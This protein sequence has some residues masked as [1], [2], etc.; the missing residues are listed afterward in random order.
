M[1]FIKYYNLIIASINFDLKCGD[2]FLL[3]EIFNKWFKQKPN[4][5]IPRNIVTKNLI[6]TKNRAIVT[7]RMNNILKVTSKSIREGDDSYF[8]N[9]SNEFNVDQQGEIVEL[10]QQGLDFNTK[11]QV[12]SGANATQTSSN[13]IQATQQEVV[14]KVSEL[15]NSFKTGFKQGVDSWLSKIIDFFNKPI[16]GIALKSWLIWGAIILIFIYVCYTIARHYMK[17]IK[18]MKQKQINGVNEVSMKYSETDFL[19]RSKDFASDMYT[20]GKDIASDAYTK[21]KD[22]A[23]DMYGKGMDMASKAIP[24]F[25]TALSNGCDFVLRNK[26]K[27][28]LGS[29]ISSYIVELVR[30]RTLISTWANDYLGGGIGEGFKAWASTITD[31]TS[32]W[33]KFKKYYNGIFASH[34]SALGGFKASALSFFDKIKSAFG[35]VFTKGWEGFKG[36][37]IGNQA[38]VWGIIAVILGL[39]T[40]AAIKIIKKIRVRRQAKATAESYIE[41]KNVAYY[42]NENTDM[43][44]TECNKIANFVYKKSFNRRLL[45]F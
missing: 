45:N 15:G 37:G 43:S 9:D 36:A 4:E 32:A 18:Q 35:D 20:K 24:E 7:D 34:G 29:L 31:K 5:P 33:L 23:V 6:Q 3:L 42:L 12:P 11:P 13:Q 38:I 2:T 26:G 40:L 44:K 28:M 1:V 41:A 39:L 25:K 10:L 17:K 30:H 19:S 22:I 16:F 8:F 21:G 14:N 27:F